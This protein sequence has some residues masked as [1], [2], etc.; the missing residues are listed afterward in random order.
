MLTFSFSLGRGAEPP[1]VGRRFGF[2][3][4]EE[5]L[6]I[7]CL[8]CKPRGRPMDPPFSSTTGRGFIKGSRGYYHDALVNKGNRV[9]VWVVESTGGICPQGMSRLRRNARFAKSPGARDGTK[10]GLS[11]SSPRS[12]LAHHMQMISAA[13]VV[14]DAKNGRRQ[15]NCLKR[16]VALASA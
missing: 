11:R 10:Y 14:S 15:L 5:K 6:R 3:N 9:I 1:S 13:A 12:Y 16:R 2:G 8:G 7:D 4:T